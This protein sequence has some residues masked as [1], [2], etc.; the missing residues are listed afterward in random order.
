MPVD[1]A[2]AN[3]PHAFGLCDNNNNKNKKSKSAFVSVHNGALSSMPLRHI[4]ARGPQ[5]ATDR[6]RPYKDWRHYN[7]TVELCGKAPSISTFSSFFFLHRNIEP[8]LADGRLRDVYKT[9]L[10]CV[11]SRLQTNVDDGIQTP[12]LTIATNVQRPTYGHQSGGP[13]L[14]AP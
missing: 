12:L 10:Q 1:E 9:S 2:D 11:F 4:C 3:F 14:R 7:E 13:P 6:L 5:T 8:Q